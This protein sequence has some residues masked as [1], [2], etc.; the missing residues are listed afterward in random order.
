[1]GSQNMLYYYFL[2]NRYS[3]APL[4]NNLE[5]FFFFEKYFNVKEDLMP[6]MFVLY[7]E[8]VIPRPTLKAFVKWHLSLSTHS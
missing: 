4:D 2:K 1:M 8:K 3:A 6:H 7:F 5:T